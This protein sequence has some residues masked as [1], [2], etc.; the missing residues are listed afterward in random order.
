MLPQVKKLLADSDNGKKQQ[1]NSQPWDDWEEPLLST[2]TD[3]ES[4]PEDFPLWELPNDIQNVIK[5][6]EQITQ[7]PIALIFASCMSV[8]SA[9]VQGI[10][11]ATYPTINGNRSIPCS[12]FFLT[13]A[14]SGER[15]TTV[16]TYFKKPINEW[17]KTTAK[18]FSAE[19][20]TY[21]GLKKVWDIKTKKFES[22]LHKLDSSNNN[23]ECNNIL[24][25]HYNVEP[26][27]PINKKLLIMDATPEAF[28]RELQAYPSKAQLSS[29]G[30][31]IFGSNSMSAEN[32]IKTL[33]QTNELW[34]G[35]GINRSRMSEESNISVS[36]VR[37]TLGI[38]IQPSVFQQ[39]MKTSNKIAQG[40]GYLAR[41]LVSHPKST[42]GKRIISLESFKN[43]LAIP[44]LD[45]FYV[46]IQQLLNI[47]IK[48]DENNDFQNIDI[49]L[50]HEAELL[51]EDFYNRN[52]EQLDEG[53][54]YDH[55]SGFASKSAEH[56][57]RLAT[58]LHIFCDA[59]GSPEIN[60]NIM[61]ASIEVMYWYIRE[62]KRFDN[63]STSSPL[64]EDR[65]YLLN[66]IIKHSTNGQ[67]DS[68][69]LSPKTKFKSETKKYHDLLDQ[70]E[71]LKCIKRADVITTGKKG[72]V[73]IFINPKILENWYY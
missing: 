29:E 15:K 38:A 48:L 24:I 12:L 72:K 30:G 73:V 67:I 58:C 22:E 1:Q 17:E 2:H 46:R 6:V 54:N 52:E 45:N 70:L 53:G 32:L 9:T 33:S 19:L 8:I 62:Q 7:A 14:D 59:S 41:F 5:E 68:S 11:N 37:V 43:K 36:Q 4:I 18:Q 16:D 50:S 39:F 51:W 35:N 66:M 25:N 60:K 56:L 40:S 23:S 69:E 27:Y 3:I 42:K 28:M 57:V 13:L 47:G 55:I 64:Q 49:T 31:T 21:K 26:T 71:I 65:M 61:Q 10:V 63:K 34:D 20:K 44:F